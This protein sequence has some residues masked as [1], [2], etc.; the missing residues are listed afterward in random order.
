MKPG[1]QWAAR[2]GG[3]VYSIQTH[4][5]FLRFRFAVVVIVSVVVVVAARNTVAVPVTCVTLQNGAVAN[6][7]PKFTTHVSEFV[8]AAVIAPATSVLFA[9]IVPVPAQPP[10]V[11]GTEDTAFRWP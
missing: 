10:F 9:A 7:V 1:R 2:P 4:M 8:F 5:Y 11:G 3:R 6:A